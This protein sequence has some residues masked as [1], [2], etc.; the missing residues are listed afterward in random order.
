MWNSFLFGIVQCSQPPLAPIVSTNCIT[1]QLCYALGNRAEGTKV[2]TLGRFNNS[3]YSMY[4]TVQW[5]CRV[6]CMQYAYPSMC[7]VQAACMLRTRLCWHVWLPLSMRTSLTHVQIGVDF[8]LKVLNW[9]AKTIVRL[10]LWDIAGMYWLV[11]MAE[12]YFPY[13]DV[14]PEV[15]SYFSNQ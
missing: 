10:Q 9:D 5:C 6:M 15:C 1:S 7:S 13:S 12:S 8:A 11:R 2:T 3:S 4:I 14:S